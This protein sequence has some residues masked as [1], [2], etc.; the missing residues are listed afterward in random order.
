MQRTARLMAAVGKVQRK[1][2]IGGIAFKMMANMRMGLANAT[3]G[4]TE[5]VQDNVDL[6]VSYTICM[7]S[8][9]FPFIANHFLHRQAAQRA[10]S[11]A[12]PFLRRTNTLGSG[13][14]NISDVVKSATV[15]LQLR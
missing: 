9:D 10:S 7:S 13:K 8:D 11:A 4:S 3:D 2:R 5:A 6:K 15:D 14:T 1:I 12:K